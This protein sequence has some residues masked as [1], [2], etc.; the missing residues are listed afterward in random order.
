MGV[1]KACDIRCVYPD[2][3]TPGLFR[4]VGQ[5]IGTKLGG[6]ACVVGGDV[7]IDL[8]DGWALCRVSVTEPMITLR[9]EGDTP[10]RRDQIRDMMMEFIE[11]LAPHD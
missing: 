5:A 6:Q 8:S 4:R 7:R 11:R 2:E 10:E 1:F 3:I 9:F